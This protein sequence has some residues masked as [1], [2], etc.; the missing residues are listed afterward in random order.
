MLSGLACSRSPVDPHEGLH[1]H[2]RGPELA[3]TGARVSFSF[4]VREELPPMACE[5]TAPSGS[6]LECEVS[7]W[8]DD[9][10]WKDRGSVLTFVPTEVGV[11]LVRAT[12]DADEFL[13][14]V[15]LMEAPGPELA[16][17][18]RSCTWVERFA[19]EAWLCDGVFLRE[20][21][22]AQPLGA[23]LTA[24]ANDALWT[25]GSGRLARV[26]EPRPGERLGAPVSTLDT[27]LGNARVLLPSSS[28]V[29][30]I[31]AGGALRVALDG[32]GGLRVTAQ[33][34]RAIAATTII[35]RTSDS[36][37]IADRVVPFV[38]GTD[39]SNPAQ[40]RGDETQV[41]AF[42]L[43]GGA[44]TETGCRRYPGLVRGESDDG[45]MLSTPLELLAVSNELD[46]GV[47]LALPPPLLSPGA[48]TPRGM[49]RFG[50]GVIARRVQGALEL[51]SFEGATGASET[52]VWVANADGTVVMSR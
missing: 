30:I 37:V 20:R 19:D 52:L 13:T 26:N 25:F 43:A 12:I 34:E 17:L 16:T 15:Y 49:A 23:E 18:D 46:D 44:I 50:T 9:W 5:V 2:E 28:D 42:S 7:P 3:L 33:L 48:T 22:P 45:V 35:R 4:F 40:A 39:P 27:G 32:Q 14:S 24:A 47:R 8:A 1:E 41:C 6:T 38:L 11:H 10:L 29:L 51:Q 21:E 31:H 36:L